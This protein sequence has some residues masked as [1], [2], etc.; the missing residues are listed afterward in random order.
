MDDFDL[1]FALHTSFYKNSFYK[2]REAQIDKIL[3]IT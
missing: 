2:D 1:F 3:R